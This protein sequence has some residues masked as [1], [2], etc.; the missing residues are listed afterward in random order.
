MKTLITAATLTA[1]ALGASA[2]QASAQSLTATERAA[3]SQM[4]PGADLNGLSSAQVSSL[5]T[6]IGGGAHMR[7]PNSASFAR[8]ILGERAQGSVATRGRTG[9]ATQPGGRYPATADTY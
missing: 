1:L 9:Q 7:E 8:H 2:V 6:I 4:V 5:R 3:V